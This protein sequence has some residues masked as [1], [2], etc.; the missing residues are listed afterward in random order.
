MYSCLSHIKVK[1]C[2]G[3]GLLLL[4]L[5]STSTDHHLPRDQGNGAE[6]YHKGVH[7]CVS[8]KC[9]ENWEGRRFFSPVAFKVNNIGKFEH[10][11][12]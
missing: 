10:L 5:V 11:Q 7:V 4:V 3:V 2:P 9:R 6:L 1:E 12:H 8:E